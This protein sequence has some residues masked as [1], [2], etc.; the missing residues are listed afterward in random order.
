M[1]EGGGRRRKRRREEGAQSVRLTIKGTCVL[2][3]DAPQKYQ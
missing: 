2:G 3:L 1:V